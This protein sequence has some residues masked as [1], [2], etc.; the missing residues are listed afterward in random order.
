MKLERLTL[1]TR[2]LD[3]ARL[4]YKETLGFSVTDEDGHIVVDA[5]G[6]ELCVD[7]EAPRVKLDRAE[8]RLRFLTD[9]LQSRCLDLRDRGVS[10]DGPRVVLGTPNS[11]TQLLAELTDPDGHPIVLVERGLLA[12]SITASSKQETRV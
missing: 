4:F 10:V 7:P 9:G 5:G 12:L 8:P 6:I 3:R 2:D 1:H 11:P